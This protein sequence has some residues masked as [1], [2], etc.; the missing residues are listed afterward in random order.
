[1][2]LAIKFSARE[3]THCY[4]KRLGSYGKKALYYNIDLNL[5]NKNQER[6][7]E[8][9]SSEGEGQFLDSAPIT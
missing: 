9:T 2:Y 3:K 5:R 1:M 7:A 6:F 4:K 8:H